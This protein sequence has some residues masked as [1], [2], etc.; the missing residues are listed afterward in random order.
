MHGNQERN[1]LLDGSPRRALVE[2][3]VPAIMRDGTVLRANVFRP[4]GEAG[5]WPVL[6]TRLPYGKDE[7][8]ELRWLDPFKAVQRG[9]MVVIQDVRGRGQSLGVWEPFRNELQDGFDSVEW[10][11]RL[12]GSNGAVGMFGLSYFGFTQW[13]A[14]MAQPPSL[15][16]IAPSLTWVRP[17][18]GFLERGGA[19]E[20]GLL[21][22]WSLQVIA[23]GR[24][25]D[26]AVDPSPKH[27]EECEQILGRLAMEGY[28]AFQWQ[29]PVCVQSHHLPMTPADDRSQ[30]GPL[31]ERATISI[32]EGASQLPALLI[33][34][35]HDAFLGRDPRGVLRTTRSRAASTAGCGPLGAR[36]RAYVQPG[37]CT[38]L[39]AERGGVRSRFTRRGGSHRPAAPLVPDPPLV[40]QT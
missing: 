39:R 18:D 22:S 5:P 15:K 13:A 8:N 38:Q 37:G 7:L 32:T 25:G 11:A 36:V 27:I 9:F 21:L 30:M 23:S 40:E 17:E 4:G 24:P 33:G 14:A 28:E 19:V 35:W 29:T 34:G 12:P 16:A 31:V 26:G 1:H 3:D 2:F 20:F 10:A 6:L